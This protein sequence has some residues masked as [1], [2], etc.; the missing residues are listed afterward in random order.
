M[1]SILYSWNEEFSWVILEVI[2]DLPLFQDL[3]LIL[4]STH[5]IITRMHTIITK[6]NILFGS[7]LTH[8]GSITSFPFWKYLMFQSPNNLYFLVPQWKQLPEE[9]SSSLPQM[10]VSSLAKVLYLGFRWTFWEPQSQVQKLF[11]FSFIFISLRIIFGG[12]F[13]SVKHALR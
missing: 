12:I 8:K 11:F 13:F 7:S 9:S 5:T 6:W 1:F 4:T 10:T 3:K 2:T